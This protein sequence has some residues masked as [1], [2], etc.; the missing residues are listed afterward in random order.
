MISLI[1]KSCSRG[2]EMRQRRYLI[3]WLLGKTDDK[4]KVPR[5]WSKYKCAGSSLLVIGRVV[6]QLGACKLPDWVRPDC[7]TSVTHAHPLCY[8]AWHCSWL[9]IP[10]LIHNEA[11]PSPKNCS[12]QVKCSPSWPINPWHHSAT[13]KS[14]LFPQGGSNQSSAAVYIWW[15]TG[16]D[17][18]VFS[19]N[20][21][22]F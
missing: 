15:W 13:G 16:E 8:L 19:S 22:T 21:K 4:D 20:D 9:W 6:W 17:R 12:T 11:K 18:A 7:L 10:S 3:E 5:M 2:R 1:E 14:R